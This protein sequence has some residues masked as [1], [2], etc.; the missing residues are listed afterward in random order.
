MFE[1]P[2]LSFDYDALADW[3]SPAT[4]EAH[5]DHHH[6]AYT[7]NLNKAVV[8]MTE[9]ERKKFDAQPLSY[10][11]QHL[12]ELP[13]ESRKAIRNQGGGYLNH[14]LYWENLTDGDSKPTGKLADLIDAKYGSFDEFKKQFEAVAIGLFG[15]GWAWLMSDGSIVTTSNQDYPDGTPILTLDVWEHAY[16]LDYQW[17]RADY[18]KGWWPHVN[19]A[20]VSDRLAEAK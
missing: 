6:Q 2:E 12:N 11:L 5:H 18:V 15:S 13:T 8:K 7:D 10:W 20:I 1:L 9:A 14:C 19:W 17:S 4:L 16:Y 3:I